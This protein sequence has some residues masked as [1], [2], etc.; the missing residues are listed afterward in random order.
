[1]CAWAPS[2]VDVLGKALPSLMAGLKP[3][4][5]IVP[6]RSDCEFSVYLIQIFEIWTNFEP[7]LKYPASTGEA[8]DA[9]VDLA[10]ASNATGDSS[11]TLDKVLLDSVKNKEVSLQV[12][13]FISKW[14]EIFIVDV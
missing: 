13:F 6:I 14:G 10:N 12:F 2:G 3:G 7:L 4:F 1:M 11:A 8:L 5:E 9:I